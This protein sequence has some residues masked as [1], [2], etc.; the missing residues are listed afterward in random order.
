MSFPSTPDTLAPSS[1][2]SVFNILIRIEMSVSA[3]E[4]IIFRDRVLEVEELMALL[5]FHDFKPYELTHKL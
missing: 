5:S 1:K 3:N 4:L 2:L